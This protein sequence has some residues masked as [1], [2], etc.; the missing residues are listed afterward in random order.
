MAIVAYQPRHAGALCDFWNEVFADRWHFSPLTP[1]RWAE[2]VAERAAFRADRLL[3]AISGKAVAG[4]IHVGEWDFDECRRRFRDW[5]RGS[6]GLVMMLAVKPSERRKG[7]G[8]RL[9]LA[10][11][12]AL[13][14]V[15]QVCL[16]AG[17]YEF[18]PPLWGTP[19][20][21]AVS[22]GDSATKKFLAARGYGPRT[23]ARSLALALAQAPKLPRLWV[24]TAEVTP[25]VHAIV[26]A[27]TRKAPGLVLLPRRAEALAAAGVAELEVVTL[28]EIEPR[29]LA[30]W[31]RAGFAKAADWALY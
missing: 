12:E 9:W 16:H 25:R 29:V 7:I 26:S 17:L 3:L 23:R 15:E 31:E 11:K 20:G 4:L 13:A 2:C 28:P 8:G 18:T 1:G 14:G 22:W 5:P 21:P 27:R 10:G 30:R 19:K 24:R 6:M